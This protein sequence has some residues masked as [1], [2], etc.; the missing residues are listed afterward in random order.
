MNEC[1]RDESTFIHP[2]AK[3]I[4]DR[5][6]AFKPESNSVILGYSRLFLTW[7]KV[8]GTCLEQTAK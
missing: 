1:I 4:Q 8:G 7:D 2:K 5:V 6:D 3:W